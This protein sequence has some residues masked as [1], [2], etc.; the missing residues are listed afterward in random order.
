MVMVENLPFEAAY[1][2]VVP[3]SDLF[4]SQNMN[5]MF[6]P[7]GDCMHDSLYPHAQLSDR[8]NSINWWVLTPSFAYSYIHHVDVHRLGICDTKVHHRYS[9]GSKLQIRD[10]L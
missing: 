3:R 2:V 6:C 4:P 5:H 7:E 1:V 10:S 8:M 9:M